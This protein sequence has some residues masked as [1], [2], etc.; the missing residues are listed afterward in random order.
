MK[1]D[2]EGA[3]SGTGNNQWSTLSNRSAIGARVIVHL[4][5]KNI[6]R[7]IE[8]AGNQISQSL[9]RSNK[10]KYSEAENKKHEKL[11]S[12]LADFQIFVTGK[13]FKEVIKKIKTTN[14]TIFRY[15]ST[16]SWPKRSSES[17]TFREVS[18]GCKS[19]A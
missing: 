7:E 11:L 3:M 10:I 5:D 19:H 4:P 16:S 9:I 12:Q 13:I 2:L 15:I 17:R 6:S 8:I 1:I 18:Q 14:S